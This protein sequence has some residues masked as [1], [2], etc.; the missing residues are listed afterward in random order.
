V[1]GG[2]GWGVA[3]IAAGGVGTTRALPRSANGCAAA[4]VWAA[5]DGDVGGHTSPGEGAGARARVGC[6]V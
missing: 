2:R 4:D 5:R 6:P 3:F 1:S